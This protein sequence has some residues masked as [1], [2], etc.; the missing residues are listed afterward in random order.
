MSLLTFSEAKNSLELKAISGV[1]G[2]GEQ[3]RSFLNQAV[4]AL[5][6]R[7]NWYG[8]VQ[9]VRLCVFDN[10]IVFPRWVGTVLATNVGCQSIPQ[11]NF[12]WEFLPIGPSDWSLLPNDPTQVGG[13]GRAVF[14]ECGI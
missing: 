8:T 13:L 1:C 9:K 10:C 6:N 3:F 2:G 11:K 5:M 12:W 7:G 14:G 4:E